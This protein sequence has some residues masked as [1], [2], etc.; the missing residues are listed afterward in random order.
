MTIAAPAVP[1]QRSTTIDAATLTRWGFAVEHDGIAAHEDAASI[2]VD[3]A[4]AKGLR[5]VLIEILAD[6]SEPS[7][8]R[9]RA[10]GRLAFALAS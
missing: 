1:A 10:F 6:P 8:A 7:A 2:I 9:T 5:P 4:T 3:A